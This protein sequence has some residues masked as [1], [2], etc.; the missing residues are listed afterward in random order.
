MTPRSA[1][2]GS[3]GDGVD[4]TLAALADPTRRGVVDRLARRPHSAGAL[5]AAAGIS[6]PAMSRHLRVLRRCGLVDERPDPADARVRIYSLR[7]DRLTTVRSWLSD[8]EDFWATQLDAF[9]EHVE[10]HRRKD[11]E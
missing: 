7:P 11:D 4:D 8:V 5:A 2:A 1:R 9:T 10:H 6:A 3:A